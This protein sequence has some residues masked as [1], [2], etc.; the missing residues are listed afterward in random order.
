VDI[1]QHLR[2]DRAHQRISADIPCRAGL[3]AGERSAAR[4]LN[5]SAGGLKFSCRRD[6]FYSMVPEDQ[7]TPGRV[8]D[9]MI[10]VEFEL[11]PSGQPASGVQTQATIIHSERLAQDEFHIGVQFIGMDEETSRLLNSYIG[12]HTSTPG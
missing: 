7:R 11:Q 4:I 10:E 5:L 6:A 2:I 8:V 12:E 1:K 9:V 3:P